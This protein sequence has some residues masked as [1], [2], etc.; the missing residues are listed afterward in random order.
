MYS[1]LYTAPT[2]NP[3][4]Y[5]AVMPLHDF[6]NTKSVILPPIL[7]NLPLYSCPLWCGHISSFCLPQ[8]HLLSRS[9]LDPGNLQILLKDSP[10]DFAAHEESHT[11]SSLSIS[12]M[13]PITSCMWILWPTW[14][15]VEVQY[16]EMSGG[17]NKKGRG[18]GMGRGIQ[19]ASLWRIHAGK[20]SPWAP[21]STGQASTVTYQV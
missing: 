15:R 6:K 2:P 9:H 19:M 11:F 16:A 12:F 21:F 20:C 3:L 10:W 4:F 13:S 8:T 5:L 14:F 18:Q 1:C 7:L 17:K